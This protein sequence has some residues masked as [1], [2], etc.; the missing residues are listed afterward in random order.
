[1]YSSLFHILQNYKNK[2]TNHVKLLFSGNTRVQL[3]LVNTSL[4]KQVFSHKKK[5]K[6]HSNFDLIV[7]FDEKSQGYSRD[8]SVPN[9]IPIHVVVE[10][11]QVDLTSC[12]C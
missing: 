5:Y 8:M 10:I 7:V 9:F 11:F 1:M 2:L 6:T 4:V 3:R 12:T